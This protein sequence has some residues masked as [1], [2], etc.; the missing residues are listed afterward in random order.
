MSE[1]IFEPET[2]ELARRRLTVHPPR[3]FPYC[4]LGIPAESAG[5][6]FFMSAGSP[7]EWRTTM[8]MLHLPKGDSDRVASYDPLPSPSVRNV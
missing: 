6:M 3:R 4:F 1:D 2:S 7:V 5:T 8:I